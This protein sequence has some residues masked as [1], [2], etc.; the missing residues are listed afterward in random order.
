MG[1]L[2]TYLDSETER[3]MEKMA[4]KRGVSKSK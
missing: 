3:K 4:K 1:Q 2:T